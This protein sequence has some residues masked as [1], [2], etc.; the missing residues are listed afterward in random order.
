MEIE[1]G[2]KTQSLEELFVVFPK[3]RPLS[4]SFC[5]TKTEYK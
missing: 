1:K 2:S 3:I 4:T 5:K